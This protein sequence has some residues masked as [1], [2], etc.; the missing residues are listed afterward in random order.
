[1]HFLTRKHLKETLAIFSPIQAFVMKTRQTF[2]ALFFLFAMH[3]SAIAQSLIT[4]H[5]TSADDGS[6][7]IGANVKLSQKGFL[8]K[9]TVTDM[10]GN[11]TFQVQAGTYTLEVG[12]TGYT[13]LRLD[14]IVVL[15]NTTP[16][17]E[18]QMKSAAALHE[19]V[20]TAYKVPLIEK[21]QT[22]GGQ[23]LTSSQI[24]SVDT[25]SRKERKRK[26]EASKSSNLAPAPSAPIPAYARDQAQLPTTNPE[27]STEQYN[28][29]NE[30]R[31][32][33]ATDDAMSTFSIDVDGASYAN[34]R[35]YL[36]SGSLPPRDAVRIEEMINYFDYQY[37][38]PQGEHPFEVVTQLGACP[39]VPNH[40][41]LHIALQGRKEDMGQLPASNLVF[42]VDVSGSMSD[43][44]KLP[45]VQKSL[46][47][48]VDQ[49]RP[50]D[51]ISLVTY[52]GSVGVILPSTSATQKETIK[53]AIDQL[54]SGGGTAGAS[55]IQLAYAEARKTFNAQHNNRVILCTDGDFNVGLSSQAE[56]VQLI[57]KERESGIYLTVLGYGTGN[58]QDGTMQALAN[59][60]N[61]NHAYIDGI[62]EAKKVLINEMGGTLFTIAKDVKLQLEFNPQLVASYRLIGYENR[63]LATEDFDNDK[64]D[65]GELGSG[66]VVTALYE[67]V[68]FGVASTVHPLHPTQQTAPN[69]PVKELIPAAFGKDELMVLKLRYKEPKG[70]KPSQLIQSIVSLKDLGKTG[71]PFQTASAVAAFGLMLRNSPHK[72]NADWAKVESWV[73]TAAKGHDLNGYRKELLEMVRTAAKAEALAAGRK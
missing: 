48:L 55:G 4:G 14:G 24:R 25:G 36:A 58:Y 69:H 31:F 45:L 54:T 63:I 11:F 16:P 42:L 37:P 3:L 60:G 57:E 61:G 6:E 40:Q 56:L 71:E 23:T 46:N 49:L 44:N 38:Q 29:I 13:N 43:E 72:G 65:A 7:L 51:R 70:S 2:L 66:H 17:L 73:K 22:S 27:S 19:V 50:E 41:L 47:L 8:V 39:W 26:A 52:A 30:N 59:A 15:P 21:D 20:V 28:E 18:L 67:I 62:K 34:I 64:K 35:R 68:P 10:S 9:G 32:K 5:V 53:S 1:M 12:Y 33:L